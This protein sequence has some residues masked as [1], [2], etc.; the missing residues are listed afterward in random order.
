MK[1]IIVFLFITPCLS[2]AQ[3]TDIINSE[4]EVVISSNNYFSL[5]SDQFSVYKKINTEQQRRPVEFQRLRWD[6]YLEMHS[7]INSCNRAARSYDP[8]YKYD[9]LNP[10]QAPDPLQ[11]IVSGT[12]DCF[13]KKA[14]Q[15]YFR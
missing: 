14:R 8:I 13:Y 4:T 3:S 1:N 6:E 2:Y 7:G 9:A 15:K 10:W 5:Y 11:A 12:I